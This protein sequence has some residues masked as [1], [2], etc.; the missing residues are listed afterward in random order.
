MNVQGKLTFTSYD[1]YELGTTFTNERVRDAEDV[2]DFAKDVLPIPVNLYC[3]LDHFIS[4]YNA[5]VLALISA[6]IV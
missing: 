5:A 4:A 6:S 3:L 2:E 1:D